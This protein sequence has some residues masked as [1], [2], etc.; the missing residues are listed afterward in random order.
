MTDIFRNVTR[1]GV[2]QHSVH[3]DNHD[4]AIQPVDVGESGHP[5]DVLLRVRP[6]TVS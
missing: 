1:L 4:A 5:A 6:D 2:E 3:V